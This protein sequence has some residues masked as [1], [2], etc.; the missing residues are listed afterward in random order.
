MTQPST[1]TEPLHPVV[2]EIGKQIAFPD[3]KDG[4]KADLPAAVQSDWTRKLKQRHDE[5][6]IFM[7][8]AVLALR[9]QTKGLAP[10]GETL[11]RLA[12][13]GL[14]DSE[15]EKTMN[16]MKGVRA[17][18]E[19]VRDKGPLQAGTGGMP[20]GRGMSAGLRGKK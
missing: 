15:L 12:Q 2:L 11:I 9:L 20:A 6:L 10:I 16:E 19:K 18:A 14:E 4:S 17:S 13:I 8:L 3:P 7:H 1:E 5:K